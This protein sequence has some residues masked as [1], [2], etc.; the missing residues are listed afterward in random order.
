MN[1]QVDIVWNRD[2]GK[3]Y[4]AQI[5]EWN[6][7]VK[8]HKVVFADGDIRWFRMERKIFSTEVD[9]KKVMHQGEMKLRRD[10]AVADGA[11]P[12]V[13]PPSEAAAVASSAEAP[14]GKNAKAAEESKP[15]PKP[16]KAKK[17]DKTV[18]NR[19]HMVGTLKKT[20]EQTFTVDG[21]WD[22]TRKVVQDPSKRDKRKKFQLTKN[23][24]AELV[25]PH[26]GKPEGEDEDTD[27]EDYFSGGNCSG[28]FQAMSA[29]GED[30]S[31]DKFD[32][33][34]MLHMEAVEDSSDEEGSDEVYEI[35]GLGCNSGGTFR[36]SGEA[37]PSTDRRVAAAGGMAVWLVRDYIS[38]EYFEEEKAKFNK[39]VSDEESVAE[40]MVEFVHNHKR[41]LLGE[42]EPIAFVQSN[43]IKA[44][45]LAHLKYETYKKASTIGEAL[46]LKCT[47]SILR[48][49]FV[50]GWVTFPNA[51]K[52]KKMPPSAKEHEPS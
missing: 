37:K 27:E 31:Y 7:A 25:S 42:D 11:R 40:G 41:Y 1:K 16:K 34:V 8:R 35:K 29:T 47:R 43:P 5:T 44:D 9:G 50:K 48:D 32:D 15:K 26:E 23:G 13:L 51:E 38:E 2:V 19:V 39:F 30:T 3:S 18:R 14:K 45:T 12:P 22:E 28:W 46:D 20:G 24:A 6:P 52:G 21:F 4:S 10:A 36:V 33:D 17:I 49:H